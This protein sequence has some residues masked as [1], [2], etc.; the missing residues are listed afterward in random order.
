MT[1]PSCSEALLFGSHDCSCGWT[2]QS[3]AADSVELTYREALAAFW[4][5]C[6]TSF[7]FVTSAMFV[8]GVVAVRMFGAPKAVPWLNASLVQMVLQNLWS[9]I[10]LWLFVPLLLR[11]PYWGF[12]LVVQTDPDEATRF[13]P[14]QRFRVANFIFWR[15]L[16]ATIVGQI[17]LMPLN[18][19]LG[20]MQISV[21]PYL[22]VAASILVVGPLIIRFLIGHSFTG[23]R[24]E[25]RRTPTA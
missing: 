23:F 3:V 13:T 10:S 18:I 25:V 5:V 21:G 24:V 16:G 11:W 17:L 22:G 20:I 9:A 7:L 2:P 12:R 19:L 4:R 1:C 8:T 15:S 6:W 14:S